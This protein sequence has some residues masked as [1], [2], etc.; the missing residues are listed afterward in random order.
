M[1]NGARSTG[2]ISIDSYCNCWEEN[3]KVGWSSISV[4][5]VQNYLLSVEKKYN[6]PRSE[7]EQTKQN[8]KYW[9]GGA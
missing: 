2:N 1:A 3:V 4:L 7:I 5:S 6:I 9:E 8:I